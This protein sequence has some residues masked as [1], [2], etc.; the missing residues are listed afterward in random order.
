MDPA[1]FVG[2]GEILGWMNELLDVS[3]SLTAAAPVQ[4]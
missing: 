1:F 2:K 3:F 4:D